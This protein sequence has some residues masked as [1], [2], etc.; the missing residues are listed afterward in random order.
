MWNR[1]AWWVGAPLLVLAL[2]LVPLQAEDWANWRG[3]QQNGVS[4]DT[5]L[6]A[7]WS[8]DAAKSE[9]FVWKAP[10]GC[11]STP[12]V[13]NGRVYI[14][15]QIGELVNEQER[16]MCFDALTGKVLWEKRFNVF[17]SDI[18]SIRLGWTNLAGDPATGN[19]FWHGTQGYLTC[20]DKDGKVLWQHSLTE[21]YGRISGYGG[22]LPG[23]T[24]A[25]D[26][27]V[28]GMNNANWGDMAKGGNR[29]LAF[30][31]YD[32]TPVWWSEPA[33]KPLNTYYSTPVTATIDGV[34]LLITGG[35]DGAAHA[36][37]AGTGKKI[38][39][40]L[41]NGGAINATPVVDG[42][43]VYCCGGE[44]NPD[45]NVQ[46]R[47]VCLDAGNVKD[48]KPALVWQK[49]GV[50]VRYTTPLLHAGRLYVCDEFAKMW[51][52]NAKDGKL[53]WKYSYGRNATGS[54]VW[55]DG[56]IYIADVNGKFHILQPGDKSCQDLDEHVFTDPKG[57]D[58]EVNGTPAIAD[59]RV[60][61]TTRDEIY[62]IGAK[63]GKAGRA[64]VTAAKV[65]PGSA[66]QI[67]VYPC[68]L[69]AKPGETL[70]LKVRVYDAAGVYLKDVDKDITWSL[71]QP[72]LPPGAKAQ[73]P[74]LQADVSDA[75]VTI[76]KSPAAQHGYVEATWNGMKAKARV[77]VLP[78]LPMTQ[79][80]EKVPDGA[81]PAAWVNCQGKFLVKTLPDGNHVL[82]KVANNSNALIARGS[83]FFGRPGSTDYTIQADVQGSKVGTDMPDI[84]VG[85]CRY[86]LILAGNTQTMRLVSW[87]A[88]PRVDKT[89]PFSW[90][91]GQWY[92]MRLQ[93]DVSG[94]KAIL[95]C[96]VWPK[97]G[98]VPD[99]WMIEFNDP[100][101]NL[102]GAPFLYGYVL[103]HQVDAPGTEV[104]YDNIAVTPNKK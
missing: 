7:S 100:T 43:Y 95:R 47:I 20:F 54:P 42:K 39:S 9:N 24:I 82:A 17:H 58:V 16:V 65:S 64:S 23:P 104:W 101:P 73:P 8:D 56:K 89:V 25:G 92:T 40:Y 90:N 96:K 29:W 71:P 45:S 4:L 34:P 68:D 91:P 102:E 13:M 55:G 48:G 51:C 60:Y 81:A 94:G 61:F 66:A 12:I 67:S 84:G 77:R 103:G 11:R 5:N 10:Y 87:D 97:G 46:G 62:C 2:A 93:A 99:K 26:L 57:D 85:A 59:G 28:I 14:N 32:G 75:K 44:E 79:D 33:E 86:T 69:V 76:K 41:F 18:V 88:M 50:K 30:N 52:F 38:W 35:A 83:C 22:R 21:E 80:F 70:A 37:Q 36:F 6:P 19:V 27:V 49:D 31:K 1:C 63:G 98:K 53:N 15:N 74:A 78:D 72:P 3:P